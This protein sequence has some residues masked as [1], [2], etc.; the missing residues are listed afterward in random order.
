M[1]LGNIGSVIPSR[2]LIGRYARLLCL[3]LLGGV[4]LADPILIGGSVSDQAG[5]PL[6]GVRVTVS[7][8]GGPNRIGNVRSGRQG[9]YSFSGLTDPRITISASKP[10]YFVASINGQNLERL[11]LDCG[12]P[13]ACGHIEIVMAPA[14]SVSGLVVDAFS[15][16]LEGMEVTLTSAA[17]S[18]SPR[19]LRTDDRGAF[20]FGGLRPGEYRVRAMAVFPMHPHAITYRGRSRVVEVDEDSDINGVVISMAPVETYSVSGQ[21]TGFE[22]G[23]QSAALEAY[24]IDADE[25]TNRSTEIGA[26]GSFELADVPRGAYEIVLAGGKRRVRLQTLHVEGNLSGVTL[27]PMPPTGVTGRVHLPSDAPT[28]SVRLEFRPLSETTGREVTVAPPRYEFEL[29]D[30]FAGEYRVVAADPNFYV[31][32]LDG[33]DETLTESRFELSAGELHELEVVLRSDFGVVSGRLK[34]PRVSGEAPVMAA[35]HYRVA[36]YGPDRIRSTAADQNGRF[37]FE[38]V[39]PGEYRVAAWHGVTANEVREE[40]FWRQAGAAVRAFPVGPGA[41]IELDITAVQ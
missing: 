23:E 22:I 24:A 11:T 32:N 37:R 21:V 36:L 20:R 2:S 30:F 13:V 15:E 9:R 29:T 31:G 18:A 7:S 34:P 14:G 38:R 25:L 41:E 35:S 19:R 10:G 3:S 33:D 12:E 26:N 8:A 1:D 39:T 4:C 40:K 6:S 16:P 28:S 27:S 17:V 5:D